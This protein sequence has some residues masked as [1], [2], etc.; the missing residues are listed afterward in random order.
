[1]YPSGGLLLTAAGHWGELVQLDVTER[2]LLSTVEAQ[3]GTAC[4]K[5]LGQRLAKA[6]N[7]QQRSRLCQSAGASL[8]QASSPGSY[9]AAAMARW[10]SCS[11]EGSGKARHL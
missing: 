5:S 3:Y 2:R 11:S 7:A 6:P 4:S 1:M 8:V 10:Q 9:S